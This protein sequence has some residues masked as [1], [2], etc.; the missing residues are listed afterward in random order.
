MDRKESIKTLL[1][2]G[3]GIPFLKKAARNSDQTG[4][5]NK[6]SSEPMRS[7]WHQWPDMEWAGPEY[8]GNRLQDWQIRNGKL[9][10][11]VS[12]PDRSLHSLTHQLGEREGAFNTS[13]EIELLNRPQNINDQVGLILGAEAG[14]FPVRVHQN[15]YRRNAVFGDGLRCGIRGDG[16]L[17]IGAQMSDEPI[18][19]DDERSIHLELLAEPVGGSYRCKL[20]ASDNNTDSL[21]T[22]VVA[23]DISPEMVS[24]NIA[25][26]SHFE[27]TQKE[28]AAPSVLFNDWQ[29]E[30]TKV[31]SNRAQIFGPICFA[32]YTLD[33]KVLKMT[34]QL[35]PVESVEN[36]TVALEF[37][38][39]GKWETAQ[40]STVDKLAR[41]THFRQENWD[42]EEAVP[43]RVKLTLPLKNQTKN[44]FYE[45]TIAAEP[46]DN[47]ELN[48]A[49]FSCNSHYGFPNDEVVYNAGR[50]QPDMCVFLGDQLYES[51]GGFGVQHAPLEKASLDWLRKW[52]MFGWSYRELFRD[53]PSAFIPDDHDVYLGNIW[54]EAGKEA[55]VEKGWG[56]D[57]QDE[58]GYKMPP[59]WVNMVHR[60]QTS[61]LPDAFDPTPIKQNI[62]V[63]YT[64]WT[65]GGVSFAIIEDRKF[66][67]AP[68]NVLPKEA[69]V[70]NGFIQNRNF[71]IKKYYDINADLLGQRQ[72]DF[73]EEWVADWSEQAEMKAVLSQTNFCTVATLPEGSILDRIVPK[74]SIPPRGQYVTG[75][76]PTT[77]MDSNGWPQ[78][79]RDEA[80]K[81][82]RKSFALHIA[83]DQHLA[84]TVQYG[85]DDFGDSGF[86][87]A[88]PALNNIWPRRWWPQ[89]EENHK[90]LA[91]RAK[92]TG[93]F[94][95]GFGNKMT[96]YG[97]ANPVQTNRKP[98]LIY[99]RAT[100]YGIIR[101][102][103]TERI[104]TI[105]CWPRYVNPAKNPGGQYD[106]WPITVQQD[107]NYGRK[108]AGHLP[109]IT[110]SGLDKPVIQVYNETSNAL[111]YAVRINS[112]QFK[113]KIFDAEATYRLMVGEPDQERWKEFNGLSPGDRDLLK[114]DFS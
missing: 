60:A 68:K 9:R 6:Q 56:Y 66:K 41:T 34:A 38:K 114:I 26:L 10:C 51:H 13:V 27:S 81:K 54:G 70:V 11:S 111:E 87:F 17:F 93:D 63:Y 73:L 105:E 109:E 24:G 21:L 16:K 50:H 101:F 98:G 94:E 53:R 61:H 43:Y 36:H 91:G 8:W 28:T 82:I 104:M 46:V 97:V 42:A 32:Q 25:L 64:D 99:D 62:Q 108:A 22:E 90:S 5:T 14:D 102:N 33:K 3:M 112:R 75:D 40:Y 57:S 15:D 83:G 110:I 1:M 80:L 48:L 2:G 100:G 4:S 67:T 74:L 29:L 103:K 30:G 92:N 69:K 19:L 106:G 35:A 44:Y 95:D 59:E 107:A 84:S 55:P 23:D 45:G 31:T 96:V 85:V 20:I 79:G 76:A 113:P 47:D 71:D 72:L 18:T 37:R 12:G 7:N 52:Y 78:K 65:Y 88:G 58:G 89:V 39:K 86:A 49:V 77:D